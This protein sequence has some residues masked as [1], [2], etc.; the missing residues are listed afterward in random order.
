MTHSSSSPPPSPQILLS[1][2]GMTCA[3]CTGRVERALQQVSGVTQ[4]QVNLAT[5]QAFISSADPLDPQA[6]IQV[7]ERAGYEAQLAQGP[8]DTVEREERREEEAL[9]L[10][11]DLL[12]ATL[13]T[14]P[15]FFVEMGGHLFPPLQ[16]WLTQHISTSTSW[17]IQ[18]ALT[19]GVLLFPGRRFYQLGL[20]ALFRG[21][22]DMNTLVALGTGAAYGYSLFATFA[23]ELLPAGAVHV[24]YEA[25]AVIVT[26]ILLGRS[27]EARAKGRTSQ[28]IQ[29]LIHLQPSTAR[30]LRDGSFIEVPTAQ[31]ELGESIE[32][33]P[34]EQVPVD[35]K[36][37][38]GSSF[39]DESMMSG[40]PLPVSKE[41]GA[42]VW[43]G[44]VNQNGLLL[45]EATA[46]GQA[47]V[48][49]QI[50][51]MVEQA[52]GAKLPIQAV[53][54]RIT[55]WFVPAVL[56]LASLTFLSWL[57]LAPS[58]AFTLA[59]T[60]AIAVLIIACPCAMGLA[61]PVS[62][63][64]ATGRGAELGVLFRKGEALQLLSE[65]RVVAFD[66]TGTLTEGKPT[67][68][69]FSVLPPF[70]PTEVLA[71][72][73]AVEEKS[74]H[75]LARAIV[76]AAQEQNLSLPPVEHFH[77]ETGAG[78]LA[79]I[80]GRSVQI[81]A[82][83]YFQ[84]SGVDLT[85]LRAQAETWAEEGKTPL[86]VAIGGQAAASLAVSD[87]LKP[88]T[89]AALQS[90]KALGLELALITG[91]HQKTASAIAERVGI[92]EVHAEVLPNG[93]A[94]LIQEL[95]Q[96]GPTVYVGDGIND[97]PALASADVGIALGTG[98]AVALEAA[99]VVLL[100][101]NLQ[102][103]AQALLLSRKTLKNIHQNLFWAFAYNAALIPLA[104]GLLHPWT[105]LSLSPAFAAGAMTLSSVFVVTNALRLKGFS[106]SSSSR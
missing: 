42:Q 75:P 93:K 11:R 37:L 91:D 24:Y 41:E 90:L 71:Q 97:A 62:I 85:L 57:L 49:Q 21:A 60:H 88:T 40:E 67:L 51:R 61:T 29:Q 89:V 106:A 81:G 6:L 78:V 3:S 73:A 52:Q 69:D 32:V 77:S 16:T 33:R 84:E 25:A 45:L 55:L 2:R 50:I 70:S 56:A 66:K 53:V 65:T 95:K 8:S 47:T 10:R 12:L 13:L 94:K 22:P 35:G 7:V 68:T 19:T 82:L 103:V 28:A 100:S 86:Y 17:L 46:V 102:G 99:D 101:G 1:V 98:T 96:R 43:G 63:M 64:V 4:V 26:L 20:P 74:E 23:P 38:E 27:L 54:D 14:L 31:V 104:A 34:G 44:T 58:P 39:V 59:L 72:I 30:V 80:D 83:R 87:P 76:Q 5:E 92:S 9:Q 105:G 79:Q 15:V 48:L 36:V 18:A